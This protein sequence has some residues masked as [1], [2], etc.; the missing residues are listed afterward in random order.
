MMY[1][2]GKNSLKRRS[3][4]TVLNY[5]LNVFIKFLAPIIPFTASETWGYF[6]KPLKPE[7]LFFENFD[8]PDENLQNFDIEEKFDK[9]IEI[10]NIVLSALEKARDKKVIG[11]SLEAKIVLKTSSE[12]YDMLS[13]IGAE[14]LK[15]LFIVSG[16]VLQKKESTEADITEAEVEKADGAKCARCWK[17]DATVGTYDDYPDIC[18]RCHSVVSEIMR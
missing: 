3:V 12:D 7:S 11:S 6:K 9:L 17:Y 10:R 16:I 2:E 4:Q 14:E 8:E 1:V 5:A 13:K 18:G 15:D